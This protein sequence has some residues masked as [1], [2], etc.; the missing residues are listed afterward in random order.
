MRHK[1]S[2][3]GTFYNKSPTDS[4]GSVFHEDVE[5]GTAACILPP[6]GED[7]GAKNEAKTNTAESRASG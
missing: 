4:A 6:G 3:C 2:F 7:L 5:A 1:K